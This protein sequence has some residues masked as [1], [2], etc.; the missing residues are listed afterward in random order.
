VIGQTI[1]HYR[2]L[3]KLGEGGMGVV[4]KAEDTKLKR[5]VALKFFPHDTLASDDAR[6]R[7][8]Y[9]AQAAAALDHPN[10]CTVHEID[11][12]EGRTFI[13]MALVE[14]SSMRE[15]IA[16][17]PLRIEEVLDIAVQVAEGLHQAHGKGVVHRDIKPS[18]LMVSS[19]GQARIMDFGL[20]QSAEQTRITKTGTTLGTVAYMS[21]EQA[22]GGEVDH[23]TDIWSFG[24]MLYEM[25]T[26]LLPFK[27][28]NEQA[29]IYSIL[30]EEPEPMTGLRTS[31]PV[32]LERIAAKAMAKHADERYQHVG[33]MLVD[34][35]TLGKNFG[36]ETKSVPTQ[37]LVSRA[38]A[39]SKRLWTWLL[40]A[41]VAVIAVIA[42]VVLTKLLPRGPEVDPDR[43]VVA[44]FDN[45]TGDESLDPIG[46][47]A[48]D[49]VTQGL[50]L[51]G[52][53]SVV[54]SMMVMQTFHT[55][56][57]GPQ[58]MAQL[59]DLARTTRAAIVVSGAYYIDGEDIQFQA[60]VT[61]AI[62]AELIYAL[63]PIRSPRNAP[64]EGIEALRQKVK[65]ALASHLGSFHII[66]EEVQ[67]PDF[68]AYQQYMA[69]VGLFGSN[70]AEAI[71]H[72]ESAVELDSTFLSP[73][74]LLV[75]SY[76]NLDKYAQA[77]SLLQPLRR[78]RQRLTP[79]QRM[80][81]DYLESSLDHDY[82]E[83]MRFLRQLEKETPNAT[84]I[85]YLIGLT[86]IRMN[87]PQVTVDTYEQYEIPEKSGRYA[88]GTWWFGVWGTALHMLGEYP[89][90]LDIVG[91]GRV[92]YPD[93]QWLRTSELRALVALGH[94]REVDRVI[95]ECMSVSDDHS[96]QCGVFC[97]ASEELRAHGHQDVAADLEERA[98]RLYE[99][100][101][102]DGSAVPRQSA[103]DS[104]KRFVNG[105]S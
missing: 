67:P 42:F 72:F 13:A 38:P 84:G 15:K 7:F 65:G 37:P 105:H 1:S 69:G 18:N 64:M 39:R 100:F 11:E 75:Y 32:E 41:G 43:V 59:Q 51:T 29:F 102:E 91:H 80:Y 73:I 79:Y 60:R 24:V 81:V 87:R 58:Q 50:S 45:R 44:V 22:R 101:Q 3:E 52:E 19:S 104:V 96:F 10:I 71:S 4:Y 63:A 26:G 54:P 34:L 36:A 68:E 27:G 57:E 85:K 70:Y 49:W 76:F 103:R 97:L 53:V 66:G 31:V 20:A 77:D 98:F 35:R 46:Q 89:D 6:A 78:E 17:G 40:F 86:A 83:S 56:G 74:I 16:A 62:R 90:E 93:S 99:T 25:V 14:G 28:A 30:N 9:E 33:E 95:D 48:A 82:A 61:D 94:L 88:F 21:P 8:T 2:I 5:T 47:M 55:P 23:R 92:I 12:V